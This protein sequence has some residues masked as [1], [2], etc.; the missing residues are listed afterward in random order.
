MGRSRW[1]NPSGLLT[2]GVMPLHLLWLT[3]LTPAIVAGFLIFTLM[4][5]NPDPV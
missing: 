2:R 1:N 4:D 5:F 3:N